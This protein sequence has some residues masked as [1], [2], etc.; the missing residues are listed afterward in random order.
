MLHSR[1]CGLV[2]KLSTLVSNTE[3]FN[4]VTLVMLFDVGSEQSSDG[5]I[6]RCHRSFLTILQRRLRDLCRDTYDYE[7]A[8]V[9]QAFADV[10]Q[11]A[12]IIAKMKL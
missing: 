7:W 8:N 10:T 1:Y 12:K 5:A 3:I 4:L 2:E 9:V 6:G 11:L